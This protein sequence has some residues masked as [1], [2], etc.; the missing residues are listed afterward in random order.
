MRNPSGGD[1]MCRYSA[2]LSFLLPISVALTACRDAPSDESYGD[3]VQAESVHLN[4]LAPDAIDVAT[5]VPPPPA[6]GS[7]EDEQDLADVLRAQADRTALD[8]SRANSE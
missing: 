1:H 6:A 5:V 3:A 4:Y 2:F 7:R 8:C